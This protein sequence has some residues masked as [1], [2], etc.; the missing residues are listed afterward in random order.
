MEQIV[1]ISSQLPDE[2][3]TNEADLTLPKAREGKQ[4]V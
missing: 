3:R 2:G 4:V 1:A